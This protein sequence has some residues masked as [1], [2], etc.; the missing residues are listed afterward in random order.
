[1]RRPWASSLGGIKGPSFRKKSVGKCLK[2]R[3]KVMILGFKDIWGA[4]QRGRKN[5]KK[6]KIRVND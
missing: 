5:L 1:V 3:E 2:I 6:Y 4:S